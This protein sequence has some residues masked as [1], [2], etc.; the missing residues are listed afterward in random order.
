MILRRFHK[1][2]LQKK[3]FFTILV[4][5]MA[6]SGTIALLARWILVSSLTDE[7]QMRG[8]AIAHSVA[9]RGAG[10]I[11]DGDTPQLVGL[12]FDEAQLRERTQLVA[13]IYVLDTSDA[14]LAHTF[15]RPFPSHLKAA[16]PLP[17]GAA[18]SMELV[19]VHGREAYDIA[20]PVREGL[21][22]IG[23]VHVGL[24]KAHMDSLV[25]KLRVTFLGF[26]T[27]V[28]IIT[29]IISH[30][31][32]RYITAPVSRLTNISDDLS[33]GNFNTAVDLD[34]PDQG[35]NIL[36][37]P[38]YSDTDLPCWHFDDQRH[39]RTSPEH[40]HRCRTC[41]FYRKRQG[42]E[43]IQL[44][45]SFRNMVWSIKLYRKRLQE[46]EG[47]YR[48]LFDSGPDPI[49]V[50][51]CERGTILDANPR[52]VEQY[53]YARE[54]LVGLSFEKLGGDAMRECPR[55]FDEDS[56]P[57]GCVHLPKVAQYHK[58]GSTFWVNLHACPISYRARPA[59]IVSTTDITE[60]LEKDAQIVQAAKM[61][62]LGE[63]SAGVAHELNQPLNAIRMGSDYLNM[64]LEQGLPVPPEQLREVTLDICGQVD[65]ATEIINTL[66]SFGRKSEILEEPVNLNAPVRSVLLLVEHQF[67][68]QNVEF[69]LHLGDALPPVKAHNNRLQQVVFNIITNARD[70]VIERMRR[71][72]G[73][74][75]RITITTSHE[76]DT[77]TLSVKDN[78][79]GIPATLR[80]QV[81][82]PFFTTK[83]TGQGMGLGLAIVYGIVRS[84]GGDIRIDGVPTGG[85]EFS[86][87]FPTTTEDGTE[88]RRPMA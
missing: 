22:Q 15:I 44:A 81:F 4:V 12:I 69:E 79:C 36:D 67:L 27:A 87:T 6:I 49:F 3:F 34:M 53:G 35:W 80:E 86:L 83:A 46:S 9:A 59:I 78:G 57:T 25:G 14:L 20:V 33:R 1:L 55:L 50:V 76:G 10:F 65:R 38:A 84:Y 62:S 17:E 60:M 7:L 75:G 28:V 26:I 16:N 21:Y 32:A 31:L 2:G 8:T 61:K 48:S 23:T 58:D 54:E 39:A 56:S 82:Q 47:K 85:T 51:D 24:N 64:A 41:V 19:R 11:L 66:R 70:A 63:M 37:C 29:F 13:Y 18:R 5:I 72:A 30:Y 73:L 42:D 77:V 71:D 40:L 43:V 68:L 74:R 52:A 88:Q 45:D